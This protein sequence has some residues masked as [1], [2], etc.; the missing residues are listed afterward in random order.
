MEQ[1]GAKIRKQ[2]LNIMLCAVLVCMTTDVLFFV[3]Y[4]KSDTLES[5]LGKYLATRVLLPNIVD[6][7][8]YIISVLLNSSKLSDKAKNTVCAFG[9]CTIGGCM[10]IFHGWFVPLWCAPSIAM[11]Y[12]SVFH[13]KK[14]QNMLLVYCI[15]L[16]TIAA[17]YISGEHPDRQSEY[18]QNGV[19]V[20]VMTVMFRL[21]GGVV[22]H[23]GNEIMSMTLA[24]YDKEREYQ[25]LLSFDDLTQ[26]YSRPY[27][28]SRAK[29]V[30][31]A[32]TPVPD[33]TEITLAILDV[34]LFKRV[35]DTY[36]HENGDEVLRTLGSILHE[37]IEK[38]MIAGR[39]GGEEFVLVLY[40]G[41]H[42]DNIA[43]LER[44]RQE[45]GNM[46]YWFC[47]QRITFSCGAVRCSVGDDFEEALAKADEALYTAKKNGRNMIVDAS[48]KQ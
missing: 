24:A 14:L 43:E 47:D 27:L 25:R 10:G 36:G 11:V 13:D 16:T 4:M 37:L 30:L 9:L 38:D 35:N 5:S 1:L 40:C 39:Y 31:N 28:V 46:Q 42:E 22:D 18:I 44:L 15:V 21:I 29:N 6:F 26:V 45:F 34:D 32:S 17:I 3:F 19:V 7:A 48:G 20:A 2:T 23:Y 12:C 8:A 33:G 41:S